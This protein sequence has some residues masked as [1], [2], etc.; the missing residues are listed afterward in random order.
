MTDPQTVAGETATK[1]PAC[2]REQFAD[3]PRVLPPHRDAGQDQRAGI[4]LVGIDLGVAILAGDES[5]E[6]FGIDGI[7]APCR[8]SAKCRTERSFRAR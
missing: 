6:R 8:A 2:A 5:A 3:A 4:D 1:R 7:F